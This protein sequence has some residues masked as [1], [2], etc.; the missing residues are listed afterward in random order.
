MPLTI[1]TSHRLE[2]LLDRLARDLEQRPSPPLA[3]ETVIVSGRG[4]GRWVQLELARRHGVAA[5][6][7]LPFPG[8]FLHG[9]LQRD[10][11]AAEARALFAPQ[12]L[13]LRLFRLLGDPA[14]TAALGPAAAYCADDPE[15]HKRMQLAMRLATCFDNYELYRPELLDAFEQ[16]TVPDLLHADWQAT[17]WQ[18]LTS[19]GKAAMFGHRLATLAERLDDPAQAKLLLPDRVSV[20][21]LAT[22]APLMLHLLARIAEHVEVTIYAQKPCHDYFGDVRKRR[23]GRPRNADSGHTLVAAWALQSREFF[24]LLEDHDVSGTGQH[25]LDPDGHEPA[26]LLHQLQDDIHNLVVRHPHS[27]HLPRPVDRTDRSLQVHSAHGP[28]R[29]MEVLRDQLLMAL[30]DDRSLAPSDIMVLLT[31]IETYAPYVEAVFRQ[32]ETRLPFQVADRD[33]VTS[34]AATRALISLLHLAGSRWT[35]REV[36]QLLEQQIIAARFGITTT[37]LPTLRNWVS[38]LG[39]RWGLHGRHR[40]EAFRAPESDAN[41]WRHGLDRLLLGHAMGPVEQPFAGMLGEAEISGDD[42]DLLG[43]LCEFVRTAEQLGEQARTA[44]SLRDWANWIDAV[45]LEMFADETEDRSGRVQLLLTSQQ[46]RNHAETAELDEPLH[47]SCFADWLQA[48]LREKAASHGF[49]TGGITFAAMQPLRTVPVRVLAVCGLQDG[50]FPRNDH[51]AGFD[52]MSLERRVGDRST[53]DDDRQLFLDALLAARDRLI[54]TYTGKSAKDNSDCAPSVPLCELLEHVDEAF[55]TADGQAVSKRVSVQHPLQAFSARYGNSSYP[56]LVTYAA[57]HAPTDGAWSALDET[58]AAAVCGPVVPP[59]A[60]SE[61]AE[62]PAQ[63]EQIELHRLLSFWRDPC[64]DYAE[65]VLQ[66]RLPSLDD[67]IEAEDPFELGPLHRHMLLQD[68]IQARTHQQPDPLR[69]A[70]QRDILAPGEL[71][72]LQQLDLQDIANQFAARLGDLAELTEHELRVT[73]H[74]YE[75]KGSLQDVAGDRMLLWTP[76]KDSL[77]HLLTPWL[78]HLCLSVSDRQQ[79]RPQRTTWWLASNVTRTVHAL[80]DM[81]GLLQAFVAGFRR[82]RQQ[83]LPFYRRAAAAWAEKSVSGTSLRDSRQAVQRAFDTD[84]RYSPYVRLCHA[85]SDPIAEPA[86]L[87]LAEEVFLPIREH[88]GKATP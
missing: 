8:G 86:F 75:I 20:F 80:P 36:L 34:K 37:D 58:T 45:V 65:Q 49:L 76:S 16:G 41:T 77:H 12:V 44:K 46:I 31:D 52:L 50:T 84:V 10:A 51:R 47:P 38:R 73:G 4:M 54:L 88:F 26:C 23:D 62:Q 13:R 56:E 29:E 5:S 28:L 27:D 78:M 30:E 60:P 33:P 21:G 63:V 68:S 74:D 48:L 25:D 19:E 69:L 17:L 57:F 24:D 70:L 6:L 87:E 64:R 72:R 85:G 59:A 83:P 53:R 40:H 55:F 32:V 14:V 9:L 35:S 7:E 11:A 42:A 3:R 67:E 79:G 71:G 1:H 66:I 82:G 15:Q 39:I 2:S 18:R 81:E 61:P 43:R 22:L